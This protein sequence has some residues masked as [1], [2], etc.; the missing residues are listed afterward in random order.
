MEHKGTLR[1]RGGG[2]SAA[3]VSEAQMDADVP[4]EAADDDLV[5]EEKF[6]CSLTGEL[7][8]ATPEA[9]TL[10]SVIEQLRTSA[11]SFR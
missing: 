2:D 5:P 4:S 7:R 1:F 9:E 10:Y 8:P 3:R 6:V 11:T